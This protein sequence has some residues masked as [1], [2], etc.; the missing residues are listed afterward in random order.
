MKEVLAQDELDRD[1]SKTTMM[2]AKGVYEDWT[3]QIR[4]MDKEIE[5]L[6]YYLNSVSSTTKDPA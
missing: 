4:E 2:K 6:R 5:H 3:K 1:Y